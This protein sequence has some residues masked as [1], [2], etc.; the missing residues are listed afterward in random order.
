M[1]KRDFLKTLLYSATLG[2]PG[3]SFSSTLNNNFNNKK[4]IVI[5]LRGGMDGLSLFVP[6]GLDEYYSYRP[7]IAVPKNNLLKINHKFGFH[8]AF[9]D[10]LFKFYQQNELVIIPQA[11]Q[12]NN[13]R[14]HF[15]AQDEMEYG[16]GLKRSKDGFLNR[17][18]LV[19]NDQNSISFTSGLPEIFKG[20]KTI[21]NIDLNNFYSNIMQEQEQMIGKMY[22]DEQKLSESYKNIIKSNHF[23]EKILNKSP[24]FKSKNSGEKIGFFMN[25]ANLNMS[26]IELLDW[27][28]HANQGVMDGKVDDLFNNMNNLL[29]GLKKGLSNQWK[30][31]SVVIMTEF[32]RTI[33]ENGALGTEHGHGSLMLLTGGNIK[34]SQILGDIKSLK[35]EDNHENRDLYVSYDYREVISSMLKNHFK[36]NK[37]AIDFVFPNMKSSYDKLFF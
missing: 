24:D 28:T 22:S 7:N 29:A 16:N 36:I 1:E 6:Y 9:K 12:S 3:V 18:S 5:L 19:I 31:T 25:Q 35:L 23:F 27:D 10:S 34:K 33:K 13:S 30:N 17:L 26:F 2:I 37:N 32:G 15:Q 20:D 11:G 8:P 14:S 4:L 21:N